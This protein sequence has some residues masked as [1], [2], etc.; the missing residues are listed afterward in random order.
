MLNVPVQTEQFRYTPTE[1]SVIRYFEAVGNEPFAF[2]FMSMAGMKDFGSNLGIHL[3]EPEPGG[4]TRSLTYTVQTLRGIFTPNELPSG[5]SGAIFGN[6]EFGLGRLF[7]VSLPIDPRQASLLVSGLVRG[8]RFELT[9][10][11]SV[12][13]GEKGELR[14]GLPAYQARFG[15]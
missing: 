15:R 4:G 7:L 12:Y 8:H 3:Q 14:S 5:I 1:G 6:V 10:H 2:D 13:T 11:H 9:S